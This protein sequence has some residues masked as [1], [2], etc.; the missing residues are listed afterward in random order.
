MQYP[1]F[2]LAGTVMA[3]V[4][5]AL[6][7][8]RRRP[9]DRRPLPTA[10]FLEERPRVLLRF[11]QVPDNIPLLLLRM[12]FALALG[13]AF[14]GL[15]WTEPRVGD[16]H[17]ILVDAGP[18]QEANWDQV[19]AAAERAATE[20]DAS[21]V[22]AYGYEDGYRVLDA[23][24]LSSLPRG[25]RPTTFEG[26]LR[27]LRD[28]TRSTLPLASVEASW[29]TSPSWTSWTHAV[30]LLR[31]AL[32]PGSLR[33]PTWPSDLTQDTAT[34][35]ESG[36]QPVAWVVSAEH[37]ARENE[38]PAIPSAVVLAFR[39]LGFQTLP[40]DTY[41]EDTVTPAPAVIFHSD[42]GQDL[43]RLI[44]AARS[45]AVVV[46]S[47]AVEVQDGIFPWRTAALTEPTEGVGNVLVNPGVTLRRS[48]DL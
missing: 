14:S 21:A 13:A 31:P 1:A 41:A 42:P 20:N 5:L 16:G 25:D 47:G 6:H 22:V 32:W 37:A 35:S 39:A 12:A 30:G 38:P 19:R 44:E 48:V 23:A 17:V 11:Q 36:P 33:M 4:V 46:V 28:A 45:G 18:H 43:P 29:I 15:S 7:L 24:T 3:A 27:A 8:L 2:L 26:G 40:L 34:V 9:P 10:R